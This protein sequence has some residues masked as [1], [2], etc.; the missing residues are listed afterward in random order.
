MPSSP[1]A[2]PSPPPREY[3]EFGKKKSS[4][5][6]LEWA[7]AAARLV[8]K[9][10]GSMRATGR[11]DLEEFYEGNESS[12][13]SPLVRR[14]SEPLVGGPSRK[15][16]SVGSSRHVQRSRS[17]KGERERERSMS[18]RKEGSSKSHKKEKRELVEE[19]GGEDTEEDEPELITPFGSQEYAGYVGWSKGKGKAV[20]DDRAS[21]SMDVD[22][23]TEG[24]NNAEFDAALILA[25][26]GRA[27]R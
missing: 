20:E 11:L 19:G 22:I 26:M 25:E 2:P 9:E 3:V 18:R 13:S 16:G 5:K 27:M 4:T 23:G 8:N 21:S 14:H 15:S 1:L 17:R 10:G 7:C 6:T 24:G 12:G